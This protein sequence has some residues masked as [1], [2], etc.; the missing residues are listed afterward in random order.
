MQNLVAKNL[1][2]ITTAPDPK[3]PEKPTPASSHWPLPG[4]Q[5]GVQRIV[6]QLARLRSLRLSGP[7]LELVVPSPHFFCQAFANTYV[8]V[9]Y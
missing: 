3:W 7:G 8:I 4:P 6:G 9:R 5:R 1:L 2:D